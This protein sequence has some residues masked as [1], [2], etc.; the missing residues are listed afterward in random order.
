MTREAAPPPAFP[1]AG[2]FE[3]LREAVASDPELAVV[4]RWCTLNVALA[5]SEKT[6]LLR[7]RE[8]RIAGVLPEPDIGASWSVTLRGTLEDWRTFLQPESPPFYQDLLAM[9]RRVPSFSIEGDR[10][11]FVR[12]LRVMRRVFEI[13]KSIGAARA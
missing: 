5:V 1:E 8:G 10:K 13:A 7:L 11:A 3:A 2:W 6:F 4:G 9:S 12:H